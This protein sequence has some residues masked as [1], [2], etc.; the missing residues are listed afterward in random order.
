MPAPATTVA[1]RVI[2]NAPSIKIAAA[3]GRLYVSG[4]HKHL[5]HGLPGATVH[6]KTGSVQLSLTLETLRAMR[7]KLGVSKETMASFCAPDVLRW[8]KAAGAV[9]RKVT[10]LHRRIADGYRADLPWADTVGGADGQPRFAFDHQQ[11]MATVALELDG[12]AFFCEM[13]TGKSRAAAETIQAKMQR[14]DIDIALVVCPRGVM[15]TWE[16]EC[17]TWTPDLH[18]VQLRGS[19]ADVR[20]VLDSRW[21]VG[22]PHTV[23]ILN[24]DKLHAVKDEIVRLMQTRKVLFLLDE[25]HKC[26][27]PQ[28]QVTQAAMEIARHAAARLALTGTPVTNGIEDVWSQMYI[29]DLGVTFGANYVQFRR[30]FIKESGPYGW[31]RQPVD[32]ALDAV[33]QRLRMRGLRYRKEDCLDL[34]PKVYETLEVEMTPEQKAAYDEMK[35]F[36][37]AWLKEHEA[38]GPADADEDQ[39]PVQADDPNDERRVATA[40]NQLV[41]ILRLTQI[42]SGFVITEAGLPHWFEPNPKLNAVDE[43]VREHVRNGR[44][45]IVWAHYTNDI[46]CIM[47]RLADLNPVRIDGTQSGPRGDAERLEAEQS[48]QSGRARV[49]VGNPAAG[50]VGLNLQ[51]ASV[52]IYYS[53]NYS[54]VTRLQSED[55]CH[56]AGSEVHNRVTYVDLV[57]AGTID[58]AIRAALAAKKD[59][60]DAVVDLR[61]AIGA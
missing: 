54:L 6:E 41:A 35:A 17:K 16:R 36:L 30:E 8:A 20:R 53:Q 56:R 22:M 7:Q 49:L 58:D 37:I 27:N 9:E 48:F 4:S 34:P 40:A 43:L 10:D 50:G 2:Y 15:N 59:V 32:G 44:S 57:C 45:V 52:A 14:L 13:G 25:V 55:R 26:K 19:I 46:D 31:D 12:C 24:Y 1:P 3:Y 21:E 61:R 38:Q 33:G 23:L 39:G 29:V 47:R 28:A 18:P 42:T 5:L 11:V 51:R 60:A